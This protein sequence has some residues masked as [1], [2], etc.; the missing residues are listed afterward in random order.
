MCFAS[1]PSWNLRTSA[2]GG[3]DVDHAR[4]A[5]ATTARSAKEK[6]LPVLQANQDVFSFLHVYEFNLTAH[7]SS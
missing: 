5:V 1:N 3:S 4:V 6:V 7:D 2:G